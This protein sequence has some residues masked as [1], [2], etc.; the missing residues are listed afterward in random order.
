MVVHP[1]EGQGHGLTWLGSCLAE[2]GTVHQ[3]RIVQ[4]LA[5]AWG[6][7][8]RWQVARVRDDRLNGGGGE[9]R[10]G[11]GVIHP[12]AVGRHSNRLSPHTIG[13]HRPGGT[14]G[15]PTGQGEALPRQ[16]GGAAI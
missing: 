12:G 7:H 4:A 11:L 9:G 16:A 8:G 15:G 2:G 1:V 14:E 3:R 13:A 5:G 10:A 6:H